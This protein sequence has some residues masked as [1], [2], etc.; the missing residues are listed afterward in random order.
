MPMVLSRN[1]GGI[2]RLLTR[3]FIDCA[4]GRASA[5]VKSDI[6]AISSGRWHLMH[7]R[8]RIGA[9]SFVNVGCAGSACAFCAVTAVDPSTTAAAMLGS[10]DTADLNPDTQRVKKLTA[11]LPVLRKLRS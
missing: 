8:Y 1:Q 11:N 3:I 6:G 2:S 4:H 5:Y 9:T 10:A 7:E